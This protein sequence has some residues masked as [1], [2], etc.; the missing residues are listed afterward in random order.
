MVDMF[1]PFWGRT[2]NWHYTSNWPLRRCLAA[3]YMLFI[4]KQII[5]CWWRDSPLICNSNFHYCHHKSFPINSIQVILHEVFQA[6][7]CVHFWFPSCMLYAAPILFF[8][9]WLPSYCLV[10]SKNM[11][12]Q[13]WNF[14]CSFSHHL[15]K[16]THKITAS[17][18]LIFWKQNMMM[19]GSEQNG[20]VLFPN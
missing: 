17:C 14:L 2:N 16:T 11:V 5:I 7:L 1:N 15:Y 13:L 10:K 18:I 12:F 9:I 4:E 3:Y 20:S 6:K 8:L 19:T